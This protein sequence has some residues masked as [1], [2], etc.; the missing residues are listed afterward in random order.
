MMERYNCTF[1]AMIDDWRLRF[2]AASGQTKPDFP[3]GFVQ[4]WHAV[5]VRLC[6]EQTN[7]GRLLAVSLWMC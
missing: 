3:F 7:P 4:V 6:C 1:P 2:S 5:C